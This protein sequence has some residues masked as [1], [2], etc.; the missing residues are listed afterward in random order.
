[1]IPRTGPSL[2]YYCD[3]SEIEIGIAIEIEKVWDFDFDTDFDKTMYMR[4]PCPRRGKLL[5]K[6]G[7]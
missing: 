1:M 3:L 6:P 2:L 7:P 4:L 5:H